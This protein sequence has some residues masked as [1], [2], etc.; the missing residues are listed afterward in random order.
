MVR[1]EFTVRELVEQ[2]KRRGELVENHPTVASLNVLFL[3][4]GERDL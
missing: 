3:Q 1:D 2:H 4:K